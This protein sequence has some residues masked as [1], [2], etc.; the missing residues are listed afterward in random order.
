MCLIVV[1][2]KQHPKYPLIFAANR[3]ESYSRPTQQAQFWNEHPNILAGK[4]LQAG[5]TWM[6]INK[7][8]HFSALTNFRDPSIQRDN[9]PS[10]GQLVLDYLKKTESPQTF[11]EHIRNNASDYMGFN[12]LV[13]NVTNLG[14]YSNQQK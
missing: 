14:Y 6:G 7:S 8:G 4:D 13:G 1:S 9:P 2:Y 3:D 5:G 11:L 12:L 10:R